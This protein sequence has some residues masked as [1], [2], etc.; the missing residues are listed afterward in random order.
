MSAT[1]GK[2]CGKI[3]FKFTFFV[4]ALFACRDLW[5]VSPIL[6][7]KEFTRKDMISCCGWPVAAVDTNFISKL[8]SAHFLIEI[9]RD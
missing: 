3:K 1:K 2:D 6:L 5:D 9:L 8:S 4:I 7:Q